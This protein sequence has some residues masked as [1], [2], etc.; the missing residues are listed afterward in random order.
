MKLPLKQE[1][2]FDK[3]NVLFPNESGELPRPLTGPRPP[4]NKMRDET[5]EIVSLRWDA[6][7]FIRPNDVLKVCTVQRCSPT[8]FLEHYRKFRRAHRCRC[9]NACFPIEEGSLHKSLHF[10]SGWMKRKECRY[11]GGT[12]WHKEAVCVLFING[13]LSLLKLHFSPLA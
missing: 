3:N 6:T 4:L 5:W 2:Y 8:S 7:P 9:R 1:K 11:V 10:H 12:L 13:P